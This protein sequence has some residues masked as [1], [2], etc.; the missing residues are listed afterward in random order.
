MKSPY[1]FPTPRWLDEAGLVLFSNHEP[2]I[3][4]R[5]T[6]GVPVDV[7]DRYEAE[8]TEAF[9]LRLK[10]SGA[11]IYITHCHKGFGTQAE[12]EE[13]EKAREL[14]KLCRK[15]GMRVGAYIRPDTLAYETFLAQE[16][17][18]TEWLQ[19]TADGRNRTYVHGQY[20]RYLPCINHEPY[21]RYL[22]DV[23]R[24]AVL[25]IGADLVHFDD[26]DLAQEPDS[27][28]CEVCR[29]KFREFLAVRYPDE[30]QRKERFGFTVLDHIEPPHFL[31]FNLEA[32]GL[33][34]RLPVINDPLL[35]DWIAF[36]CHYVSEAYR[37]LA[38][39]IRS[40]NPQ[41]AVEYNATYSGVTGM[42]TP[43]SLGLWHPQSAVYGSVFWTEEGNEAG[44]SPEGVLV[45]KIRT[46]KVA[47]ALSNVV[48]T[49][50]QH[51][52]VLTELRLRAECFAYNP[53][54]NGEVLS[55]S[56][57]PEVKRYM[58]FYRRHWDEFRDTETVADVAVLRSYPSLAHNN[59]TTHRA[60]ILA[61]QTLIQAKIPFKTVFDDH[62]STL[63]PSDGTVLML[64]NV[65][66]M[67]D[68]QASAIAR[69]VED[70]GSI[71][72]TEDTSLYDPWRRKRNEFAL[73]EVLRVSRPGDTAVPVMRKFGRGRA[74]YIPQ[75][76]PRVEPANDDGSFSWFDSPYWHLPE[77]W[78]AV[79]L[80]VKWAKVNDLAVEVRAPL[81]VTA[82]LV[83][84][85][86][87][88]RLM[89][90]LVNYQNQ[91]PVRDVSISLKVPEGKAV[92]KVSAI[93]PDADSS[94]DLAFQP[95]EGR[96][97][98][99]QPWLRT[100]AMVVAETRKM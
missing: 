99:T 38:E 57:A 12:A 13:M 24:Y 43:F 87:T 64:A 56:P 50:T 62:L 95:R 14:A 82:E 78:E 81:T 63:D 75:L 76:T 37:R 22:E 4:R 85:P 25:E 8:H 9:V 5:R 84:Q 48:F 68:D 70:G 44:I 15:H 69:F 73:S 91:A 55:P 86:A 29:A 27:C 23:V 97:E 21:M 59:Y 100:Y 79:V 49:Y 67:S 51:D 53:F 10:E 35:Q 52:D 31:N 71:V 72:A 33:Y 46:F 18:A 34:K 96:V 66:S 77:N 58:E 11:N 88:N 74:A 47:R 28:H 3:F 1:E 32:G 93:S 92:T 42:N 19:V 60:V 6:G 16:P 39:L 7:E 36:R 40:L 61:E 83:R 90:H 2:L 65:E 98:F 89:L 41:T 30:G 54:A 17:Q 45:S 26:F 20:F 94:S 80:A